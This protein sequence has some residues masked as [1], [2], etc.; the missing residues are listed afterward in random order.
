M[1]YQLLS[2]EEQLQN[3]K[4]ALSLWKSRVIPERV[5]P[6]LESW[7]K[8][9][10][11]GTQYCFGGHLTTWPE[12]KDKYGVRF[13]DGGYIICSVVPHAFGWP[14]ISHYLFGCR[15]LF[16]SRNNFGDD[17]SVLSDYDVVTQR[18]TNQIAVLQTQLTDG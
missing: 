10:P 11:C 7:T 2:P 15:N 12:F 18:L 9:A 8:L 14:E 13:S 6:R 5:V 17:V 4:L 16:D 1:T 3:T